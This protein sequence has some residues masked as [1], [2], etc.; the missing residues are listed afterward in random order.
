MIRILQVVNNMHRAGLETM[1][2]NYYRNIDRTKI[3]FDFLT[4]RPE[5]GDYDDEILSMGGKVYYA[6]RLY[7][8]NY[9]KYFKFMK[10][11]F[12]E[13][14][15][16]KI[17]H[18]HIDTM[19]FLPL[20]AA[21]LN[22]I[23]IRIAHS[24]NT[25]IDKDFKLPLKILFKKLLPEIATEYF[26]CGKEAGEFLFPNK[27]FIFIPNAIDMKNFLYNSQIREKKRKELNLEGKFVIGH[28]GRISYQKNHKLLIKIF[29]DLTIKEKN[30]VL[31]VIGVGEKEKE[32]KD[33]VKELNL[34]ENVLFLGKRK[35]VN[36]LYQVM[37]L[38]LMPSLFEGVPVVGVEAQFSGLP[39]VFSDKVP[40]EIKFT[41]NVS[42]ISLKSE[43]NEWVK[44]IFR[45]RDL[46]IKREKGE[47]KDSIFNI[48][49]AK[50]N[51]E[52]IYLNLEKNRR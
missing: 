7:P 34:E 51:L 47:L 2:M 39:C 27:N 16:Y 23:P 36:E 4:H 44:E 37:D 35:D 12:K 50:T 48:E 32:I 14:P 19:S 46:N 17:I 43:L 28:I 31:L 22:N 5:K 41:E 49:N 45:L 6:P 29:K 8:Q 10:Q 30:S 3:Q 18:S 20:L 42:F 11:F 9:I 13:H 1:L 25:S 38:F 40:K 52:N 24:H 15:E 26:A 33:L 21:K